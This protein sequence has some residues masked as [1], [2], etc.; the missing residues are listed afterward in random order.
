MK[1]S[2]EIEKVEGLSGKGVI[3]KLI[4]G[5]IKVLYR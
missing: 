2:D 1:A 3:V 5:K 4:N